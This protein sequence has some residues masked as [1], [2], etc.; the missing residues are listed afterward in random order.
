[1][2]NYGGFWLSMVPH[3]FGK[4]PY[5]SLVKLYQPYMVICSLVNEH[6]GESNTNMAL[7]IRVEYCAA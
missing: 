3:L 5:F 2:V 6:G 1:M 7:K 4:G